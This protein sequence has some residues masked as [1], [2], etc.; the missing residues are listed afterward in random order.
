M[1]DT[2]AHN[3]Q[4]WVVERLYRICSVYRDMCSGEPCLEQYER[5]VTLI[6]DE[7]VTPAA[8]AWIELIAQSLRSGRSFD[9]HEYLPASGYVPGQ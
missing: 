7:D 1:L 2:A 5:Q 6:L 3:Q 4:L 9:S 8:S